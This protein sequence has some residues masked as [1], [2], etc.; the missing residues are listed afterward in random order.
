MKEII[1]EIS[2]FSLPNQYYYSKGWEE[3]IKAV[4]KKRKTTYY[5]KI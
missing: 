4:L 2:Y 3:E 1:Q 5:F